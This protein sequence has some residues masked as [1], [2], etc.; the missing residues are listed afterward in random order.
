MNLNNQIKYI[1]DLINTKKILDANVKSRELYNEYPDN[2]DIGKIYSFTLCATKN[3]EE[4]LV[5]LEKLYKKW[6]NDYD[7]L[8]NLG[9]CSYERENF[10]QAEEILLKAIEINPNGENTYSNL[11][12][13]YL[14]VLKYEKSVDSFRKYIELKGGNK[15]VYNTE[16]QIAYIDSLVA[17]EKKELAIKILEEWL[18]NNFNPTLYFYLL[19]MN[20]SYGEA[21]EHEKVLKFCREKKYITQI[22]QKHNL[23]A[24][25]F[26]LARFYEKENSSLA[27]KYY[28]EANNMISLTQRFNLIAYQKIIKNI[29]KNYKNIKT[30][31]DININPEKGKGLIFIVG[32]PRSGTTLIESILANNNN[33]KS[34]GELLSV[35]YLFK[36]F[37]TSQIDQSINLLNK[38]GDEYLERVNYIREESK[39]IVDKLPGNYLYIGILKKCLPAAKFIL[40]KRNFWDTAISQFR[41]Y[42]IS[43]VP[44]ST[45][46]F[47]IALECANFEF[48]SDFWKSQEDLNHS[49]LEVK[50]DDVV[51]SEKEMA[52]KMYDFIG[53]LEEYDSS[54][55][56][57]FFSRTASRFE[58]QRK[59]KKKPQNMMF[60]SMQDQFFKDF[61]AQKN[62]WLAQ[63]I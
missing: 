61:D 41:Q 26:A 24:V 6:P 59:V 63:K 27:E 30:K 34:A 14:K 9:R 42:Y 31:E 20:P 15:N 56:G 60:S 16:I 49:I 48:T 37:T 62:Y 38:L 11:G 21:K 7:I 32:L 10:Y 13:F 28:L 18:I 52:K 58:V 4:A 17:T 23:S 51:N 46:F 29:I 55:R 39:F 2:F 54:T 25:Y 36:D 50:Y 19:N 22:D 8:N 44:F 45:K 57:Q 35:Q 12:L 33:V 3:Y 53:L 5:V 40:L 43:S 1:L 47:N